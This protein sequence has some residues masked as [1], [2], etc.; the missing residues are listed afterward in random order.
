MLRRVRS[1]RPASIT[2]A[3]ESPVAEL[4]RRQRRYAVMAVIF[5][6]SFTAAAL[7]Y[8]HTALALLLCGVAMATLVLAVI[9]A[10]VRSPRRRPAA[11]GPVGSGHGQVRA[12]RAER[13]P[14]E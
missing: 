5:V 7:L 10:N 12:A 4:R 11:P 14:G 6:A 8:R 13:A 9:G 1:D 3:P 2:T